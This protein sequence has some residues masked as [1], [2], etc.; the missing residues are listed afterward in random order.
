MM[1]SEKKEGW[2]YINKI[3][4]MLDNKEIAEKN[5]PEGY[6]VAKVELEG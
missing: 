6:V 4:C 3:S 5:C 2:M 1:L